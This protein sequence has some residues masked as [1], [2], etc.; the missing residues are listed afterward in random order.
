MI[1][2]PKMQE[3]LPERTIGTAQIKHFEVSKTASESTLARSIFSRDC[4]AYV[5][6][7]KYARLEIAGD[8]VMSDTLMEQNS[9]SHAVYSMN[10]HA[11]IAGLGFGMM[12]IPVCRKP[13]VLSI[14]VIEKNAD[15]IALVETP[16]RATLGNDSTKV[17]IINADIFTWKPEKGQK[18]DT[19]W[20]DIWTD[21]CTDN[22]NEISTLKRR[23]AKKLNRTNPNCWMGA[24]QEENLRYYRR[25]GR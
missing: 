25:T 20:F 13:E 18:F 6:E 23:F 17:K 12:L 21:I 9:N 3:I 22:L 5:P 16:V 11:L 7:G 14:T 1:A 24:W 2:W 8:V 19:I 15:V 4:N 10:G